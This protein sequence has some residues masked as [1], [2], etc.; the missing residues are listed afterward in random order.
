MEKENPSVEKEGFIKRRRRV[1]DN[2]ILVRNKIR[3]GRA[4]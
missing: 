4:V 2:G 1:V 3:V